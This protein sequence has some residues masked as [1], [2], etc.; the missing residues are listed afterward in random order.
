[1]KKVA[2][3][4]ALSLFTLLIVLP[5]VGTVNHCAGNPP[6][7][8]GTLRADGPPLPIPHYTSTAT[9]QLLDGPPLP[10]PH[11]TSTTAALLLDGP[12]LPIPHYTSTAAA[13][14]LDGPPLPIPHYTASSFPA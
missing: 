6:F 12:P 4:T 7:V 3:L 14:L 10:I 5:V 1:M 13:L 8:E 2:I 9:A 11:Y